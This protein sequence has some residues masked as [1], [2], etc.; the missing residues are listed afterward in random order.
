MALSVG[1]RLTTDI[2][3]SGEDADA[4]APADSQP[5]PAPT[6]R[7][8]APLTGALPKVE[9]TPTFTGLQRQF[10]RQCTLQAVFDWY[11]GFLERESPADP[12]SHEGSAQPAGEPGVRPGIRGF[13]QFARQLIETE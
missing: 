3:G 8:T 12:P 5:M 9:L 7:G 10:A 6:P 2:P 11:Q 1:R 13:P 4:K